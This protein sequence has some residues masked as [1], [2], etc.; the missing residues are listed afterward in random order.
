[1]NKPVRFVLVI[2]S[3]L[4]ALVSLILLYAF[5]DSKLLTNL[6]MALQN[7]IIDPLFKWIML[8]VLL[9]IIISAVWAVSYSLL[10]GRL[11]KTRIRQTDIGFVDIG[12]DAIES[13]ALNSAKS[14]QV[15]IKSAK[16]HV[17]SGKDDSIKIYLNAVLYSNI[18]VPAMMSKVQDRIKKDIERY[19]GIPVESVSV[20]VTRVEP[21][22]A[23]VER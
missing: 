17:F 16:A 7:I 2:Y 22:V 18:E 9:C 20:K 19:T 21:V 6:D 1:M 8:S 10:S 5:V 14:A 11:S 12:V 3:I 15:G 13:I 4:L 23:K